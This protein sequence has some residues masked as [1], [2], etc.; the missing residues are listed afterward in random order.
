VSAVQ[1][2]AIAG[3]LVPK[4][5]NPVELQSIVRRFGRARVVALIE[6]ASGLANARA[7][8][9][10]VG[11][12]AFGSI[13]FAADLGCSHSRDALLMARLELVLASRLGG[14]PGPTDGVTAAIDDLQKTTSDAAYSASLGFSGKLLIH[15]NQIAPARLGF[16]PSESE[17]AWARR[18][19]SGYKKGSAMAIDG[20]MVDAPV[21]ARAHQILRR[22]ELLIP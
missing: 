21:V 12:I 5:E 14:L 1:R 3:I 17:L 9:E 2:L 10:V 20:L 7:L 8:A 16:S 18:V 22:A 13:D 6:T 4:A 11:R 19:I 15:P